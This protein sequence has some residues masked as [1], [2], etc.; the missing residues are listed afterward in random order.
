M[1]RR[2]RMR[3]RRFTR[4]VKA[5]D[6]S[7]AGSNYYVARR[8]G[9]VSSLAGQQGAT[10]LHTV[11]GLNGSSPCNDFNT[12]GVQATNLQATLTS[13]TNATAPSRKFAVTGWMAETQ[14]VNTGTNTVFVDMYYWQAKRLVPRYVVGSTGASVLVT[15][16]S[17]F[18]EALSDLA[19]NNGSA[20]QVSTYGVTPYQAPQLSKMCRIWKKVRVKLG[21]GGVTQVET[22]SGKNYFRNGSVDEDQS[23]DKCTEG[24][25]MIFYGVPDTTNTTATP[26]NLVLST[27]INYT[28]KVLSSAIQTGTV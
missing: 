12:I 26:A 4:Q 7:I 15:Y 24:I 10:D 27:N 2:K 9:I 6:L 21:P 16:S 11:C 5:V 17:L 8:S 3:W 19:V 18:V 22:R 13:T 28:Y 1:P 23:M 14:I 25:Y 20:L